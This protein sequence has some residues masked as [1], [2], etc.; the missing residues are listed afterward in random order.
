MN[1]QNALKQLH[2]VLDC[3]GDAKDLRLADL[4]ASRHQVAEWFRQ[5]CWPTEEPAASLAKIDFIRKLPGGDPTLVL[6]LLPYLDLALPESPSSGWPFPIQSCFETIKRHTPGMEEYNTLFEVFVHFHFIALASQFYWLFESQRVDQPNSAGEAGIATI[7]HALTSDTK[8]GGFLWSHWAGVLSKV[9]ADLLQKAE[10]ECPFPSLV[11]IMQPQS[12]KL[13]AEKRS[14]SVK[15]WRVKAGGHVWGLLS[16]LVENRN[17]FSHFSKIDQNNILKIAAGLNF[18]VDILGTIFKPY[19]G[20]LL[21]MVDEWSHKDKKRKHVIRCCWQDSNLLNYDHP[22]NGRTI[23]S[24][25]WR[26]TL[27]DDKP[28]PEFYRDN[29]PLAPAPPNENFRWQDSLLIF[30]SDFPL[31]KYLYIM[32]L[33][34]RYSHSCP[35]VAANSHLP[36]LIE[37]VR[38]QKQQV[39]ALVQRNYQ[40]DLRYIANCDGVSQLDDEEISTLSSATKFIQDLIKNFERYGFAPPQKSTPVRLHQVI[41]LYDLGHDRYARELAGKTVPR[42][43]EVERIYKSLLA[44]PGQRAFLLGPSGLGKSVIM[45]Q[46]FALIPSQ[47]VFLS[48]DQQIHNG[49][50]DSHASALWMHF[51]SV[52]CKLASVEPPKELLPAD[53]VKARVAGLLQVIASIKTEPI[54]VLVDGINQLESPVDVFLPWPDPLPGNIFLLFS[55]QP[56]KHIL[57]RMNGATVAREDGWGKIELAAMNR[58]EVVEVLEKAWNPTG[59]KNKRL[60]LKQG[61]IDQLWKLSQ[62]HP[63][64]LSYWGERLREVYDE[65]PTGFGRKIKREIAAWASNEFPDWLEGRFKQI[66]QDLG[67]E[68]SELCLTAFKILSLLSTRLATADIVEALNRCRAVF[69]LEGRDINEAIVEANLDHFGGFLH[70]FRRGSLQWKLAHERIAKWFL[71]RYVSA[72]QE[73]DLRLLLGYLGVL[74]LTAAAREEDVAL[75]TQRA[76]QHTKEFDGLS[77]ESQVALLDTLLSRLPAGSAD[78]A[79][80]LGKLMFIL[81]HVTGDTLR[82]NSFMGLLEKTIAAETVADPERVELLY[83]QGD[84][85]RKNNESKLAL[86]A[87]HSSREVAR[88][89]HDKTPSAKNLKLYSITLTKLGQVSQSLNGVGNED[90]KVFFQQGLTCLEE[91]NRGSKDLASKID[92]CNPLHFLGHC[93]CADNELAK[94]MELY[95]RALAIREKAVHANPSLFNRRFHTFGLLAVGKVYM[96]QGDYE[97]TKELFDQVLELREQLFE[98]N[99]DNKKQHLDVGIALYKQGELALVQHHLDEAKEFFR[100]ALEIW[101]GLLEKATTYEYE[102]LFAVTGSGLGKTLLQ[103]GRHDEALHYFQQSH[104]IYEKMADKEE[105]VGVRSLLGMSFHLLALASYAEGRKEEG[106][107]YLEKALDILSDVVRVTTS[108]HYKHIFI[109]AWDMGQKV[110]A[111]E[112]LATWRG[113]YE[114]CRAYPQL[115]NI[116]TYLCDLTWGSGY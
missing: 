97:K 11:E 35:D 42:P 88:S 3:Q 66:L 46:L 48:C 73:R 95:N 45:A 19:H 27:Y 44:S 55:S 28:G 15:S 24:A 116:K 109:T 43:N 41:G 87:Y 112:K 7:F 1:Y 76:L 31:E 79:K 14:D 107:E 92:L 47:A 77:L 84:L 93:Y 10:E 68:D 12:L 59:Q 101:S 106:N 52:L 72:G 63:V 36:G 81:L 18:L 29:P 82:A 64:F 32:P 89:L 83:C 39:K 113:E 80:L 115:D 57:D 104:A 100:E 53:D 50:V 114:Q 6:Q 99:Q 56:L 37:S 90:A 60:Q 17:S 49:G 23:R 26:Q 102:R 78:S 110:L 65:N 67:E 13:E 94:A 38:W 62:G 103:E 5:A 75:W 30:S 58:D 34:F 61:E 54:V 40:G 105:A 2:S 96:D 86:Q 74:Q 22:I 108:L 8:G 71:Q 20:L 4:L 98:E 111:S 21:A 85:H 25:W 91:L 51:V 16:F 9:S 33:G 69:Q 70:T